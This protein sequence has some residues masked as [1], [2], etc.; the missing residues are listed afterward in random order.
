MEKR[1]FLAIFL[2]FVVLA[3]YQAFFAPPPP[4]PAAQSALTPGAPGAATT[5]AAP[6]EAAP[7]SASPSAVPLVADAAVRDIVVE[8]DAIRAVFSNAG[9]V[10]KQWQLKKYLEEGK[11]LELVPT[12][13]PREFARPFTL[14]TDDPA[15]SRTLATALFKPSAAALSLGAAPGTLSFQYSD[16]SGLNARKTFYFQPEGQSYV[17][18]VE[19]AVDVAGASRPAS[20]AWGPGLGLGY[21]P[22]GSRFMPPRGIQSRAGKVERLSPSALL[23]QSRYDGEMKFA[24]V[25]DQY[26]LAAALP[27][28]AKV[29]LDYQPI[30]LPVPNDPKGQSR[31]FVG[32]SVTVPGSVALPFFMGPKDFDILKNIDPKLELV[33]AIDFG[34]FRTIVVPLLLALKWINS[35]TGNYGW[36]IIGLTLLINLIIF[37]LRHRSMVSMRKMQAVQPEVKLIQERYAKYKVTDPERQKMNTEMMAL[38]KQRGVNPASGCLPMLLTM[39]VLFAFYALLSAAIELRGAPFLLWIHDLS[40]HDPTYITP[41]IMGGT[42][43]LQQRMMPSTADPVQ[44]KVLMFMPIIFT[45]SFLWAPSG[46]VVYW[47]MSNLLAI[48]Q[49]ALTNR[50]IGTPVVVPMKSRSTG[51][52]KPR[53]IGNG[54]APKS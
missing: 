21:S 16:Q 48:G 34:M 35:F 20:L 37:P 1:V 13:I 33:Y 32:Y 39:P 51:P 29:Q 19:A 9:A 49:Q 46:L 31:T 26:F 17:L 23:K 45:A 38:Y 12:D 41:V 44:Q 3:G 30:T 28:T 42:M 14:S 52:A 5:P 8:T 50:I 7:A 10:L 47:L 15:L 2:S 27:G 40:R 22:D 53:Q 11:P 25:E 43:F 18:K 4:K 24:G 54:G 36:S 6:L